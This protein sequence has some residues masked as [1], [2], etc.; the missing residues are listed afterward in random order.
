MIFAAHNTFSE[1]DPELGT[2]H[3]PPTGEADPAA[4]VL[5]H[6]VRQAVGKGSFQDFLF[7]RTSILGPTK[8]VGLDKKNLSRPRKLDHG[9]KGTT[10]D[11]AG[12]YV[13]YVKHVIYVI[14]VMYVVSVANVVHVTHVTH[15][16]LLMSR[17]LHVCI[18]YVPYVP[19]ARHFKFFYVCSVVQCM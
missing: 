10:F 4:A 12:T 16:M 19:Y 7:L 15:V 13:T 6:Y 3:H 8:K 18:T 14:H 9:S 5:D 17:M 11:G 1:I 2:R